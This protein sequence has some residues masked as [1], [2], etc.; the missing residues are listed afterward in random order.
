MKLLKNIYKLLVPK[1][2]LLLLLIVVVLL[3]ALGFL[4][5]MMEEDDESDDESDDE[6]DDE[7]DDE[8]EIEGMR[9]ADD[10]PELNNALQLRMK[11]EGILPEGPRGNIG[12]RGKKGET[13]VQGIQGSRGYQGD[14]GSQG[15]KGD[16]GVQGVKGNKGNK[17]DRG[18]RG[19]VGPVD[20]RAYNVAMDTKSEVSDL[21][22]RTAAAEATAAA[23]LAK[24]SM[25]PRL[26]RPRRRRRR[27]RWWCDMRLKENILQVGLSDSNIPIYTYKY[28][29]IMDKVDGIDISKTYKGVIAQDLLELGFNDAVKT[30]DGIYTVDYNKIDVNFEIL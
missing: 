13:G 4:F 15:V 29:D 8:D 26:P 19:P 21:A 22:A 3:L 10:D 7:R 14:K 27:R 24:A 17:G 28:K 30:K 25:P 16:K 1:S 12:I 11:E 2:K 20:E 23:A 5:K 18:E 9:T 6:R